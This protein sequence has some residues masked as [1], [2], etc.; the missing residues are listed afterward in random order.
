MLRNCD[1]HLRGPLRLLLRLLPLLTL[2]LCVASSAC[3]QLRVVSY[4]TTGGPQT[5]INIILRSIGEETRNGFAKPIDILLLQEQN[6]DSPSPGANNPSSDTQAFVSLLNSIYSNPNITYAMSNRTGNGDTTQTLV[7]RQQTVDLIASAAVGSTS[8]AG[9]PRQPIRFQVRPKNYTAAD[10]YI[11]NSHYKASQGTDGGGESSNAER[12]N[13]EAVA[14]RANS[15]ALPAATHI[16][17]AGDHNFYDFDADEP[18]V[19]TLL[20]AGNG[21]AVDPINQVGPWHINPAYALHHTQ[22]PCSTAG[23]NCGASGGM[24]DRFDFQWVSTEVTDGEG[25]DYIAGSYRAFGNNGSTFDTAINN[26]N[27]YDFA[28][29]GV[30]TFTKSQ[31]LNALETVTDHI[32]VVADY[33]L[34]AVMQAIADSV[35]A[36]L[37][38]GQA[39]NL[40]VTVTNA[41]NVLVAAGADELDYSLMSSGSVSGS[42]LNQIDA[43]LGSGNLHQLLLNTST[44]GMKSGM[45]TIMSTSQM[46]QNGAIN[47]P[48]SYLVL[49]AGD[50]NQNGVVD[51]ADYILW[52][53]MFGQNVA[54]GTG[55]DGSGNGLIDADDYDVWTAHFGEGA[56]GVGAN[57]GLPNS[58]IPEPNSCALLLISVCLTSLAGGTLRGWTRKS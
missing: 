11:Y 18:A 16:I 3:A 30:T 7:Y 4:N 19:G 5:G 46:V 35:P 25:L 55:A 53:N 20:A 44:P 29:N 38:V 57:A 36:T 26:G 31:I 22:S 23:G 17:Y 58:V 50:Y 12:R 56:G 2:C 48:I 14:I 27:T 6:N 15:N 41:A 42:F 52:R 39:F 54:N 21:Q 45:I 9:F 33:Q 24:D 32:P 28:A 40:G 51:A 47:I 13:A 43:A 34:P 10:L 37:N 8:F 1:C 49:L